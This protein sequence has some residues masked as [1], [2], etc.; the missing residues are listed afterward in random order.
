MD[1]QNYLG[2]T[3]LQEVAIVGRSDIV[4]LLL[5]RGCNIHHQNKKGTDALGLAHRYGKLEVVQLLTDHEV[6]RK[7]QANIDETPQ[8]LSSQ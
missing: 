3:P 1:L 8:Q 5:D 4:R 2:N 6:K 7:H